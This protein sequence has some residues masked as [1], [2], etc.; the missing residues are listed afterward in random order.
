MNYQKIY[1]QIIERAKNRIPD[2]YIERHHIIPKCMGGSDENHNLV[3]LTP[4]EHFVAH[5]LLIKIYPENKNLIFACNKMCR[6]IKTSRPKRKLYGWLKR[7]HSERISE[8]MQKIQSGSNNSQYGTKWISNL[9]LKISKRIGKDEKIPEGWIK[10]RVLDWE[11]YLEKI[12]KKQKSLKIREKIINRN[13]IFFQA[14]STSIK[15]ERGYRKKLTDEQIKIAIIKSNFDIKLA[16][17][18]LGYK[19]GG[20][21]ISRFQRISKL[22]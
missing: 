16:M 15:T 21:T 4:E 9:D 8:L 6:P 19:R 11:N 22:I 14:N 2:G 3:A 17:A 10:S 18:S 5:I 1:N 13:E 12:D 7:L 20:N